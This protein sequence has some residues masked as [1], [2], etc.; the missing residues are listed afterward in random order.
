MKH[1]TA[2]SKIKK[3]ESP[4]KHII[5]KAREMPVLKPVV[6]RQFITT[7]QL[8]KSYLWGKTQHRRKF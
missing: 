5:V 1:K 8:H 6:N 2:H 4:K 7:N 3:I